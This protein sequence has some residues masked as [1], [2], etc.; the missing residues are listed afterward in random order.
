MFLEGLSPHRDESRPIRI[1]A[2]DGGGVR[3]I[4]PAM[5]LDAILGPARAQDVFDVICGTSTGGILACGLC[6]P[7][8]L[9]PP[10]LVALYEDHAVEIFPQDFWHQFPGRSLLGPKYSPKAL[11]KHLL[12][13]LGDARL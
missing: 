5:V 7:N 8:P 13:I 6:K 12:R 4:I 1:L 11:E 9:S 10:D 3:G 2:I